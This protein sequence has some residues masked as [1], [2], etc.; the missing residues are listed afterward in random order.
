MSVFI[1]SATAT[2]TTTNNNNPVNEAPTSKSQVLKRATSKKQQL[3]FW[4]SQFCCFRLPYRRRAPRVTL[5]LQRL[6]FCDHN[7]FKK[8][9]HSILKTDN[10]EKMRMV[11]YLFNW[12]R[13][14]LLP[15]PPSPAAA[16]DRGLRIAEVSFFLQNFNHMSSPQFSL[17]PWHRPLNRWGAEGAR[18]EK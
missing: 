1:T 3:I 10:N 5:K 2:T 12:L 17:L 11:E 14:P 9:T 7:F 13:V 18:A 6:P 8:H 4:R 15:P 16:A